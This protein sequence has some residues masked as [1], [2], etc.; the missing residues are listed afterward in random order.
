MTVSYIG[1]F[2]LIFAIYWLYCFQR[3]KG[4]LAPQLF[5]KDPSGSSPSLALPCLITFLFQYAL[6]DYVLLSS[7][8][9]CLIKF[10]KFLQREIASD[11]VIFKL[12]H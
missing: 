3:N 5:C 6:L 2:L 8:L 1:K 9:A 10:V 4:R 7:K 11:R 12:P